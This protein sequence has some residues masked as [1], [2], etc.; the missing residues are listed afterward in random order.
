MAGGL[1]DDVERAERPA[2][3]WR[4]TPHA[5]DRLGTA[6]TE[7]VWQRAIAWFFWLSGMAYLFLF[8]RPTA[9]SGFAGAPEM[10]MMAHVKA[11]TMAGAGQLALALLYGRL[12]D[13]ID[14]GPGIGRVQAKVPDANACRCR[15]KV[16]QDGVVTGL[17]EGFLWL[18][19]GTLYFK[20]LQTAFR[21]N[22]D[23]VL[24]LRDWPKSDRTLADPTIAADVTNLCLKERGRRLCCAYV[25]RFDD[26]EARRRISNL[27]RALY[28]WLREPGESSLESLLP[29]REV[30]PSLLAAG[31]FRYEAVFAGGL[32]VAA[33][34]LAILLTPHGSALSPGLATIAGIVDLFA[35]AL[36]AVGAVI[37][38][39]QWRANLVRSRL[40]SQESQTAL[41]L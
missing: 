40:A 7:A 8:A 17:D 5:T 34:V 23:D 14:I 26:H 29:P 2:A 19:G 18:E 6:Y 39:R 27:R 28:S 1:L 32:M 4:P 13:N 11:L 36:A 41:F 24:P 15:V 33:S 12:R 35:V 9:L 38:W 30:H 31:P 20:G 3:S 21:I 10:A 22:P 37:V 16:V 25:E